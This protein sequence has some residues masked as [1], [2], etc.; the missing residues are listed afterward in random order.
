MSSSPMFYLHEVKSVGESHGRL[1]ANFSNQWDLDEE[2]WEKLVQAKGDWSFYTA[3]LFKTNSPVLDLELSEAL[4][5]PRVKIPR[6]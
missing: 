3:Y 6:K 5:E 4:R 1:V 2:K